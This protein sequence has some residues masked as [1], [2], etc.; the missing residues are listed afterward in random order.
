MDKK[1]NDEKMSAEEVEQELRR[2]QLHRER[3]GLQKELARQEMK[4]KVSSAVG[5]SS[6]VLLTFFLGIL[7][8]VVRFARFIGRNSVKL[9]LSFILLFGA[10]AGVTAFDTHRE[11]TFIK[12]SEEH[13]N[14]TCGVAKDP[15]DCMMDIG[16]EQCMKRI[17]CRL[18]EERLFTEKNKPFLLFE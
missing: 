9:V 13:I 8:L 14:A 15:F 7:N 5:T 18:H 12:N 1:Y 10:I 3:I 17:E 4:I 11:D 6:N 16:V 2:I